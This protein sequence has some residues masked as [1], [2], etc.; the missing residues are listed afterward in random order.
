MYC[1][2][3]LRKHGFP[4]ECYRQKNRTIIVKTHQPG[5]AELKLGPW[6]QT[7]VSLN[8]YQA[9]V[10]IRNPYDFIVANIYDD[11]L[12]V[13]PEDAFFTNKSTV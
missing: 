1:D 9:I 3:L 13:V 11:H 7:A 4:Y 2:N 12:G 8:F 10:L 5:M 6:N